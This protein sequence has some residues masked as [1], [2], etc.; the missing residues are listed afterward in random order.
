MYKKLELTFLCECG[1]S[2]EVKLF[3]LNLLILFFVSHVLIA[4][5]SPEERFK[6]IVTSQSKSIIHP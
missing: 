4:E 2:I 1:A 5:V 6:I 3:I